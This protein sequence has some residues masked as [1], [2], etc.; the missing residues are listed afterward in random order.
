MKYKLW[1]VLSAFL[2]IGCSTG[3]SDFFAHDTM[4]KNWDHARYSWGGYKDTTNTDVEKSESQ[5]WWGK[6][7]IENDAR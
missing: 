1:I 2:L 3:G 7:V 6:P 5:D 4:Y